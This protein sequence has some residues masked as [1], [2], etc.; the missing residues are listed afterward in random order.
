MDVYVDASD[1]GT[2]AV[3]FQ[4][5]PLIYR[6]SLRNINSLEFKAIEKAYELYGSRYTICS[7]NTCAI[8]QALRY[9]KNIRI[10]R[11]QGGRGNPAHRYTRIY[12]I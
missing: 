8:K 4:G 6:T 12:R 11:I 7:D 3:L 1:D 10:K 2:I 5:V 9:Y